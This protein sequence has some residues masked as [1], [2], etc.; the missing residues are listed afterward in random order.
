MQYMPCAVHRNARDAME[1]A[2]TAVADLLPR[3]WALGQKLGSAKEA[4]LAGTK[5]SDEEFSRAAARL[6]AGENP[7]DVLDDRYAAA[8]SLAGTPES[9]IALARGVQECR[10]DGAGTDLQRPKCRRA[11]HCSGRGIRPQL[12]LTQLAAP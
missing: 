6:Y 3:F 1:A 8:F 11:N 2:K 9:C 4:L 5:I 12:S 10:C 7:A